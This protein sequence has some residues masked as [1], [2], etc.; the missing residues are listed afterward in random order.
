VL[1]GNV[2]EELRRWAKNWLER[3]KPF[4][5]FLRSLNIP[6][7]PEVEEYY[8]KLFGGAIIEALLSDKA[9]DCKLVAKSSG[10]G[11]I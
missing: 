10:Y 11:Y 6:P 9:I 1:K 2:E 3:F 8:A 7:K 5:N 4:T